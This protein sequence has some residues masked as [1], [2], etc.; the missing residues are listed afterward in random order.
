[1][2]EL[3]QQRREQI[4]RK[5]YLACI[6]PPIGEAIIEAAREIYA[7]SGRCGLGYRW[8]DQA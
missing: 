3:E 8:E 4:Y 6:A 7:K 5:K 2:R 1:M